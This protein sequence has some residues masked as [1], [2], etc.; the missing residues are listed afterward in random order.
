MKMPDDPEMHR[1]LAE[2]GYGPNTSRNEQTSSSVASIAAR[3][4]KHPETL[5]PHEIRK[6]CAS[7][8]TQARPRTVV[9][10]KR[11]RNGA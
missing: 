3:G 2:A 10:I 5:T 6:V 4:I 1:A 11:I 9:E 7:A 8:L